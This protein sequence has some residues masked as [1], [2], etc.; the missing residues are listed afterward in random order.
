VTASFA[1]TVDVS[2]PGTAGPAADG[3][4]G[5][6]DTGVS[7]QNS[8]TISASG[9]INVSTNTAFTQ[10]QNVP[11]D[12]GTNPGGPCTD[13]FQP[14]LMSWSLIGKIGNG[15][16]Q[17]VGS[18][19]TTLI[20]TGEV[21]LAVNDD[22]YADNSGAWSATVSADTAPQ[23]TVSKSGTGTGSVTS[24]PAGIDCGSSCSSVF[25][26]GTQVTLTA[27]PDT[28]S[29]FTGWSGGGCSGTGTCQVT[30]NSDTA[31]TAAFDTSGGVGGG[32][33]GAPDVTT[34]SA[35]NVTGSGATVTGLVDPNGTDTSYWF[36]Y[37]PTTDYGSKTTVDDAGITNG[38]VGEA[39]VSGLQASTLYHYRIVAQRG[40][41]APV[42]G[43]DRTFTTLG[44]SA[45]TGAASGITQTAATLAGT[46]DP[47]GSAT[48]Y[49][50]DYGTSPAYGESIPASP[51][52]NVP[53]TSGSQSVSQAPSDLQPNTTY[54]YRLVATNASGTSYGADQT[55]KTAVPPPSMTSIRATAFRGL[56]SASVTGHVDI[57]TY[58]LAATLT[59]Q[60]G[61][62]TSYG[63]SVSV[64]IPAHSSQTL[65]S[66]PATS[67]VYPG[68][69]Y[70]YRLVA[71]SS[72][73]TSTSDDDTV[74]VP[75]V[76]PAAVT[77]SANDLGVGILHLTGTVDPKGAPA[78]YYFQ[79]SEPGV[80]CGGKTLSSGISSYTTPT[81]PATAASATGTI[82]A[83][84]WTPVAVS[85]TV[86]VPP[87][88]VIDYELVASDDAGT[89][90]GQTDSISVKGS[91]AGGDQETATSIQPTSAVLNVIAQ[92]HGSLDV[93]DYLSLGS[94]SG[95]GANVDTFQPSIGFHYG[96]T[97]GYGSDTGEA[98]W[99]DDSCPFISQQPISGLSPGT[100]Y[101]YAAVDTGP[102]GCGQ[103]GCQYQ[104]AQ[105]NAVI[106]KLPDAT[107]TT[108]AGSGGGAVV[109]LGG[110][111]NVGTPVGCQASKTC[112]GHVQLVTLVG[113]ASDG[114]VARVHRV[115]VGQA[116]FRIAP[117][118]RALVRIKLTPTG[119]RLLRQGRLGRVTE[120][121]R[122]RA[123]RGHAVTTTKTVSIRPRHRR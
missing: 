81:G 31:I 97:S 56:S 67:G 47:R 43:A 85:A 111:G 60:Y 35:H 74:T 118:H 40:S 105:P 115:V 109:V 116:T 25:S 65:W 77:G 63:Q 42:L 20:G 79:I 99:G 121:L 3:G 86:A 64:Q 110:G 12:G 91:A 83:G 96:L 71:T 104:P 78:S 6:V 7:V 28:G 89:S 95:Y 120:V 45:T 55:F 44:P 38:F 70:H 88:Q 117:H 27:T 51:G 57:I 103:L 17:E 8:V 69:S 113:A 21:E 15:A 92:P 119:R 66:L 107:F 94:H 14:S 76:A 84:T 50:F 16:W 33:S 80:T 101:H 100:T 22:G 106:A 2:V 123:G 26:P 24:S 108:P 48:T 73:G 39:E 90:N 58:G 52:A 23:L 114:S 61:T 10:S 46:V 122:V 34:G 29:T 53:G 87:G 41:G 62:D 59:M 4:T 93:L 75:A 98:L 11:P 5:V 112:T 18:G 32:T 72:A 68:V 30:L 9:T 19:P 49:Y 54:H 102:I 37:G 36:E 82:A 13:C 1:H